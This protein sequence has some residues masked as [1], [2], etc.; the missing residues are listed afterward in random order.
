VS[1]LP[2]VWCDLMLRPPEILAGVKILDWSRP[3]SPQHLF[4]VVFSAIIVFGFMVCRRERFNGPYFPGLFVLALV[5]FM[6]SALYGALVYREFLDAGWFHEP[7]YTEGLLEGPTRFVMFGLWTT[8]VGVG[9]Y[10]VL[11]VIHRIHVVGRKKRVAVRDVRDEQDESKG[12]EAGSTD[13]I[14]RVR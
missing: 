4:L 5:P 2:E 3:L 1:H 9:V 14:G 11:Y 13:A 12:G 6:A 7:R 10:S 8:V